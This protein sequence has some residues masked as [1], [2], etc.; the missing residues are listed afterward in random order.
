MEVRERPSAR[1][2]AELRLRLYR[3][4]PPAGA[5]EAYLEALALLPTAP[6]PQPLAAR[7]AE[8]PRAGRRLAGLAVLGAAALV[9]V[10]LV[11]REAPAPAGFSAPSPTPVS[12]ST[13]DP[14]PANRFPSVP[15]TVVGVMAG[16]GASRRTFDAGG[17]RVVVS[18]LCS[19]GGI[20]SLRLGAEP[21]T[22]LSCEQRGSGLAMVASATA[23]DS[24]LVAVTPTGPVEFSLAIGTLDPGADLP[25]QP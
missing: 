15:G 13:S 24:L 10:A 16:D 4:D 17:D 21:P 20:L 1:D 7:A 14:G 23:F 25:R 6:E 3:P 18:L 8:A 9:A 19:G 12:T 5:V 22:V 2:A 11:V